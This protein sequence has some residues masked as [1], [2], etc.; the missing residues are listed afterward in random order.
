MKLHLI[1][2]TTLILNLNMAF[3]YKS[4][5]GSEFLTDIVRIE[6]HHMFPVETVTLTYLRHCSERFSQ[7]WSKVVSSNYSELGV[8][9]K[10][11]SQPCTMEAPVWINENVTIQISSEL[12]T[13]YGLLRNLDLAIP[14]SSMSG[15]SVDNFN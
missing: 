9:V 3:G 11:S 5:E 4:I 12:P 1:F 7:V 6:Q 2:V 8:T 13:A 15:V 14:M 10:S